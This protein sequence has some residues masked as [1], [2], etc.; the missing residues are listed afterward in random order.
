MGGM[1]TNSAVFAITIAL[2]VVIWGRLVWNT[3]QAGRERKAQ[4]DQIARWKD[5]DWHD[6]QLRLLRLEGDVAL[7]NSRIDRLASSVEDATYQ[8]RQVAEAVSVLNAR[9]AHPAYYRNGLA[10]GVNA[11]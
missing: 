10:N 8:L 9:V 4:A 7:M 2:N 1:T 11:G 5:N 3:I 6:I